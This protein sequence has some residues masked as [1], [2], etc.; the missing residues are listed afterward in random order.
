MPLKS[1]TGL[2]PSSLLYL[3]GD[4]N[5]PFPS[6][7]VKDHGTSSLPFINQGLLTSLSPTNHCENGVLLRHL[8]QG[9][10]TI[11][12]RNSF[13]LSS[14]GLAVVFIGQH[15]SKLSPFTPFCPPRLL[16]GDVLHV[17]PA[18]PFPPVHTNFFSDRNGICFLDFFPSQRLILSFFPR[19]FWLRDLFFLLC[20][21][22]PSLSQQNHVLFPYTFVFWFCLLPL[23]LA[24]ARLS[25]SGFL[26]GDVDVV[27]SRPSTNHY[28]VFPPFPPLL[29]F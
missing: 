15:L 29:F 17:S 10:P 3:P 26:S 8:L 19:F 20:F 21:T 13:P 2:H 25:L 6:S 14:F 18:F 7:S 9:Q 4:A 12:H 24:H 16:D 23:P 28:L 22:H 27:A 11:F 5:E 1:R